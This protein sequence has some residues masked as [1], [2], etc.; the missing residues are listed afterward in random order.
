MK[1]SDF[2]RGFQIEQARALVRA[3]KRAERKRLRRLNRSKNAVAQAS[4][5]YA[6]ARHHSLGVAMC[7]YDSPR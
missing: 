7:Q 4:A 6:E 3:V 1:I 5:T 2:V